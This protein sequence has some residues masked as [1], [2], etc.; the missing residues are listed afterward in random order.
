MSRSC[1]SRLTWR[2][3]RASSSRSA[4]LSTSLPGNGLPLSAAACAT[5]AEMLCEVTPN[6]RESSPGVRPVCTS[7]TI[8]RLNSAG[9]GG[10][11]WGMSDSFLGQDQ[12]SVKS[13]QL[14]YL[15]LK[16][17]LAE[18]YASSAWDSPHID[19]LAR[20]LFEIDRVAKDQDTETQPL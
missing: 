6:S 2:R 9:Y 19:R 5:Q 14:Q 7:S 11:D 4:V 10:L 20:E 15:R 8:W 18:A 16:Q 17:E 12:V 13:A 1:S 3:R